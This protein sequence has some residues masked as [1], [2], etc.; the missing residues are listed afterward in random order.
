MQLWERQCL[1][2]AEACYMLGFAIFTLPALIHLIFITTY[3]YGDCH[4]PILQMV[5]LRQVEFKWI[6]TYHI[7]QKCQSCSKI[8]SV[9]LKSPLSCLPTDMFLYFGD[10]WNQEKGLSSRNTC[11]RESAALREMPNDGDIGEKMR[12]NRAMQAVSYIHT[13]K[14][15]SEMEKQLHFP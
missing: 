4:Y 15:C 11:E 13:G 10:S 2:S 1:T 7:V 9:W 5:K 3:C 14:L 8:F 12:K 6:S